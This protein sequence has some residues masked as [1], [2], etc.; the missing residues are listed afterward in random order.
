MLPLS[1]AGLITI[2]FANNVEKHNIVTSKIKVS[3]QSEVSTEVIILDSYHLYEP[4]TRIPKSVEHDVL[5]RD[6]DGDANGYFST[7]DSTI[8]ICIDNTDGNN[9]VEF[10]LYKDG[11]SSHGLVQWSKVTIA[12]GKDKTIELSSGAGDYSYYIC[13]V[14]G[15]TLYTRVGVAGMR[16]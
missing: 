5:L 7:S 14:D 8:R 4:G 15:S 6:S 16:N 2:V 10:T 1:M 9:V 11:N 12:N 13:S 3:T